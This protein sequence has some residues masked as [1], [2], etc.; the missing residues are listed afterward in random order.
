M[1]EVTAP[2]GDHDLGVTDPPGHCPAA[3]AVGVSTIVAATT[4]RRTRRE[5]DGERFTG[6]APVD[7][8]LE[9]RAGRVFPASS[10]GG[11]PRRRTVLHP[12]KPSG[13]MEPKNVHVATGQAILRRE[14]GSTSLLGT[15]GL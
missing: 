13:R 4:E 3:C 8:H 6:T 5:E 7:A 2:V 9:M 15:K 11:R 12:K 14:R 10:F 1:G